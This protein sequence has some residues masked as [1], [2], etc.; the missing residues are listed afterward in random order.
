PDKEVHHALLSLDC[1]EAVVEEAI[2][3]GCDVILSHHPIVFK[4]LKRFNG[5]NYVERVV[6]M[7]IKHDIA[8]YAIHTNLDNVTGGVNSQLAERLG[9]QNTRILNP[10]GELLRKLVVFVPG[11]YVETVRAALFNAGA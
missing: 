4:G 7:A 1:T 8:L 6:M 2:E 5:N 3:L 10:K 9:L 11:D